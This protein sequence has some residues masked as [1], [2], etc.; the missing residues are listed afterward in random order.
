LNNTR[1]ALDELLFSQTAF[2]L[3]SFDFKKSIRFGE[4][5]GIFLREF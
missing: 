5:K 2:L 1:K 3:Y 4:N